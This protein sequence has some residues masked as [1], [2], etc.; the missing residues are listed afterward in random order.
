MLTLTAL[1][2]A[3]LRPAFFRLPAAPRSACWIA[4]GFQ[5]KST[6]ITQA[7]LSDSTRSDRSSPQQLTSRELIQKDKE[8]RRLSW[9]MTE[10]SNVLRHRGR[11]GGTVMEERG[12]AE[13]EEGR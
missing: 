7:S 6:L 4:S 5:V 13:Q 2:K 10:V 3:N 9:V 11:E 12:M 8:D 1:D